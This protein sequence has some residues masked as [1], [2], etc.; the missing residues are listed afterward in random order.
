[1]MS[2]IDGGNKL[3]EDNSVRDVPTCTLYMYKVVLCPSDTMIVLLFDF[4]VTVEVL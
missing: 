4:E 2:I 3:G 1:M